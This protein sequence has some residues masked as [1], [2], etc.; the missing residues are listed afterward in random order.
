MLGLYGRRWLLVLAG[1][2]MVAC[3]DDRSSDADSDGGGV[4]D[5]VVVDTAVAADAVAAGDAPSDADA[6]VLAGPDTL[7]GDADSDL[8]AP[9]ETSDAT[10]ADVTDADATAAYDCAQPDWTAPSWFERSGCFY[11]LDVRDAYFNNWCYRV[12]SCVSG[13]PPPGKTVADMIADHDTLSLVTS[14]QGLVNRR[15][16]TLYLIGEAQPDETWL[17]LLPAQGV[18]LQDATRYD[19]ASVAELLDLFAGHP[20]LAG[21]VAWDAAAPY[22]LNVAYS[23]AGALDLLVV[24]HGG[25]YFTETTSR[26]PVV[27]DLADRFISKRAAYEWLIAEHLSQ[28]T[29]APR[30]SLYS[31]GY[32]VTQMLAGTFDERGQSLLS[33]DTLVADRDFIIG[34]GVHAAAPDPTQSPPPPAGEGRVVLQEAIDAIR[35]RVGPTKTFVANGWPSSE[36]SFDCNGDGVINASDHVNCEEWEWV[37]YLSKNA[38]VLRGGPAGYYAKESANKSFFRHGPGVALFVQPPP[39]SPATI[40]RERYALGPPRNHSFELGDSGWTLTST[41][42]ATYTNPAQAHHGDVFL[43]ANVSAADVGRGFHQ[44]AAVALERGYRYRFVV[45]ARLAAPYSSATIELRVGSDS[46]PLC[47]RSHTLSGV[48]WRALTCEFQHRVASVG[49]TRLQVRLLTP[50]VNVAF[51]DLAFVGATRVEVDT[52]R[53]FVSCYLGDYDFPM[54]LQLVPVGVHPFPWGQRH[55]SIPTASGFTAT[56]YQDVPPLFAYFAKTRTPDQWFVMPDSGAGYVNPGQLP[57]AVV[58]DWVAITAAAQRPLGYR[59]GWVLNGKRW[60]DVPATSAA[61]TKIRAMYRVIAPEGIYYNATAT[62]PHAYDSGL[63]V[64]PLVGDFFAAGQQASVAASKLANILGANPTPFTVLRSVFVSEQ[65]IE[66]AVDLARA[67]GAQL[68]VVDPQTFMYLFRSARGV[69]NGNRLTVVGHTLP[70]V[71]GASD[72]AVATVTVRNDGW[73]LWVPSAAVNGD[74]DG[75]GTPGRGCVRVAYSLTATP[76][77]PVG[78]GAQPIQPYQRAELPLVVAPGE[79]ATVAVTLTAPATAGDYTFQLDGVREGNHF[80]ETVGNV[81]W[82]TAIRVAP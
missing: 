24:R 12:D 37:E 41:N 44:D 47:S 61:G 10:A 40:L 8:D 26:F 53:N 3:A 22:T 64:L 5:T 11:V 57:A 33:R 43:Q 23:L 76:P 38:G 62:D 31:D 34:Y 35:T 52:S 17:T 48:D 36:Y 46:A 1:S 18:W 15:A 54:A 6:D 27:E 39:A 82:Q 29:L 74:C 30:L 49:S 20:A 45:H 69:A 58:D 19:V 14:L 51:D 59:S 75:T 42:R 28:G 63:P 55:A 56:A 70:E 71:I 16:P 60:S 78:W 21:S 25:A 50:G 4:T 80:F 13:Q 79:S 7:G 9:L 32:L 65:A 73:D 77:K 66:A 81:P 2:L 68:D 67:A 72:V